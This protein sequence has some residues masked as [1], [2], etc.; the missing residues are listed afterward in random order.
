MAMTHPADVLRLITLLTLSRMTRSTTNRRA[1]RPR[2]NLW[3]KADMISSTDLSSSD[4]PPVILFLGNQH[5]P[6]H[7]AAGISASSFTWGVTVWWFYFQKNCLQDHSPLLISVWNW[8]VCYLLQN[9]AFILVDYK[10]WLNTPNILWQ[11]GRLVW[12][13]NH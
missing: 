13:S 1:A 12:K 8:S 6:G 9:R 3:C 4:T 11:S 2:A 10:C 5:R 7:V